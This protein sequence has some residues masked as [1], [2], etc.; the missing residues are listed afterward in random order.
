MKLSRNRIAFFLVIGASLSFINACSSDDTSDKNEPT[1][2]TTLKT[3]DPCTEQQKDQCFGGLCLTDHTF[4][5]LTEN[6]NQAEIPN[7]YCSLLNCKPVNAPEGQCGPGAYC[8][9]L[10]Q[11]VD[12]PLTACFK[13]CQTDDDCR[14]DEGYLC[15]DF[16]GTQYEPLP[17]KAC[18]PPSLLC[19]LDVATP[20]C[21]NAGPPKDAGPSDD[22][23]QPD[24]SSD[25]AGQSDASSD[26]AGQSD[27][28]SDDAGQPD[29][30]SD[31]AGK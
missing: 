19:L 30:S 13:E 18:L 3:G 14:K 22:A 21:P 2:N 23:G 5:Q 8:F 26:D 25:D 17:R 15:T 12:T 24:A 7:G 29:A 20:Q 11:F 10:E 27:A 6:H 9:D 31:D 28:S 16:S 4:E 1:Q